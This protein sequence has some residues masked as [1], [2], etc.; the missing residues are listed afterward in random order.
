MS[1]RVMSL[2]LNR[3]LLYA[4]GALAVLILLALLLIKLLGDGSNP[5]QAQYYPGTYTTSVPLGTGSVT[6]E[7]VFSENGIEKVNYE[8]PEAVQKVYP[9]VQPT[10]AS[11]GD[12]LTTGTALEAV[13]IDSSSSETASHLLDAMKLS[14]EKAKAE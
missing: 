3:L 9:L 2:K 4:L 1:V 6:V 14:M 11:I 10:A 13:Q 12:Q 7:M 5:A 8:I